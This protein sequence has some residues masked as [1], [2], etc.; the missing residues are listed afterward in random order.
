M[1]DE[2][3]DTKTM[4]DRAL[5]G[6]AGG[7]GPDMAAILTE[8]KRRKR[9]RAAAIAGSCAAVAAVT[10]GLGLTQTLAR[11]TSPQAEAPVLAGQASTPAL[12]PHDQSQGKLKAV[13]AQLYT[14]LKAHLPASTR[15]ALGSG[16]TD[17]RLTH[18]DGTVTSLGAVVGRQNLAGLPNPCTHSHYASHCQP[19]DLPD[20]SRG[21]A[22]VI[23]NGSGPGGSVSV[24]AVTQEGQAFGLE[25]TNGALG[26]HAPNGT[27]LTQQQLVTLV[28]QPD[29]LTALQ[30]VPTDEPEP[31]ATAGAHRG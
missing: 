29:V 13:Q 16:P 19:V 14:A 23:N 24:T 26:E 25:D 11:T 9:R 12:P 15:I 4:L 2:P 18:P 22:T 20:G 7:D 3:L 6:D 10:V 1:N 28:Q 8:G 27:L 5:A 17:F 30:K 31:S 21:W